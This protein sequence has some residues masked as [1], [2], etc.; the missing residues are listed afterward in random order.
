MAAFVSREGRQPT[1]SGPSLIPAI[2]DRSSALEPSPHV[3]DLGSPDPKQSLEDMKMDVRNRW[4]LVAE[5]SVHR[6]ASAYTA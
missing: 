4:Q 5:E 2:N 1:H 6:G 3:G